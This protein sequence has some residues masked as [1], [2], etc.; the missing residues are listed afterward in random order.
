[1]ALGR[2]IIYINA[3]KESIIRVSWMTKI[4][5]GGDV[6]SF[7]VQSGGQYLHSYNGGP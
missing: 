4:F 6:F 3:E 5:V 2:T 1:M 7:L